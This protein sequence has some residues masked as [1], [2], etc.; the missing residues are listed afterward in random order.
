MEKE[1]RNKKRKRRRHEK[2]NMKWMELRLRFI[3]KFDLAQNSI[4]S[5]FISKERTTK[6]KEKETKEDAIRI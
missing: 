3:I 6:E 1:G 4:A 5:S 2:S